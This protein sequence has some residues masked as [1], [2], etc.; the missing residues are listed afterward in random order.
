MRTRV[1]VRVSS[2]VRVNLKLRIQKITVR[3]TTSSRVSWSG[4]EEDG[5]TYLLVWPDRQHPNELTDC[6]SSL[7]G[8]QTG[9]HESSNEGSVHTR[10]VSACW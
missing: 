6:P 8:Y 9:R 4:R 1:R 5:A 2:R 7:I 10:D 3:V